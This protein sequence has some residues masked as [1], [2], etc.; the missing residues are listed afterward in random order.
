MPT[1]P[2]RGN[3]HIRD[4]PNHHLRYEENAPSFDSFGLMKKAPRDTMDGLGKLNA[5]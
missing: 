2:Q 3:L 1:Q 4:L 5:L